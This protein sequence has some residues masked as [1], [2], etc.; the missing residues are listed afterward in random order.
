LSGEIAVILGD[1]GRQVRTF[2]MERDVLAA[3]GLMV[4]ASTLAPHGRPAHLTRLV[5]HPHGRFYMGDLAAR[6]PAALHS[7]ARLALINRSSCTVIR[8]PSGSSTTLAEAAEAMQA[9]QG[10]HV[11]E[12]KFI[13]A[14][15]EHVCSSVAS[16]AC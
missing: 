16:F 9:V 15:S 10:G 4:S 14:S 7:R 3:A 11:I 13:S 1:S 6:P 2:S 8:R 12:I 5:Q